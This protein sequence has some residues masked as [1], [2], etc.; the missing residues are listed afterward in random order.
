MGKRE[1]EPNRQYTDE[2]KVEAVR[3]GESIG[4]SRAAKRLGLPDSSLWNW[5]AIAAGT[6]EYE[7]G[8]RNSKKQSGPPG[9]TCWTRNS[10][11]DRLT[12]P[13]RRGRLLIGAVESPLKNMVRGW[14]RT[15]H[16]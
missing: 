13:G 7:A 2:F 3:L 4:N 1:K 14:L 12:R 16:W 15:W 11:A 10:G 6:G 8:L 5:I 9:T